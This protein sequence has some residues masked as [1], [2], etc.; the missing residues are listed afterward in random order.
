MSKRFRKGD[1]VLV[2]WSDPAGTI[3]EDFKKAGLMKC[4]TIG[5]VLDRRG[6]ELRLWTSRYTDGEGDTTTLNTGGIDAWRVLVPREEAG[7]KT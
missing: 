5:V 1:V 3:N 2:E 7:I 4:T 6:K